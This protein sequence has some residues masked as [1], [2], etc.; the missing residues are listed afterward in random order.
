M[1]STRRFI[2]FL[3]TASCLAASGTASG[4]HTQFVAEN[5]NYAAPTPTSYITRYGSATVALRAR[6]EGYQ[7]AGRYYSL[8]HI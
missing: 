3:V 1:S 8:S 7:W 4:Y 6:H 2:A 5:C